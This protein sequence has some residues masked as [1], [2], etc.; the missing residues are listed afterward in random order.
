MRRTIDAANV[1]INIGQLAAI[2]GLSWLVA[3]TYE[4]TVNRIDNIDQR[5]AQAQSQ[6]GEANL[7]LAILE[8]RNG[9]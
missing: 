5:L 8:G 4:R 6:L 9:H 1:T 3:T 7:R 2:L